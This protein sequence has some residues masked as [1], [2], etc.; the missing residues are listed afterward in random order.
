MTTLRTGRWSTLQKLVPVI[1]GL[2]IL[3]V[4]GLTWWF[5]RTYRR[6]RSSRRAQGLYPGTNHFLGHRRNESG[7]SYS[8]T[9]HLNAMNPSQ[10]SLP[11][12]RI[13]LFFSGMLPVRERRR[14]SDWNIE[15][16]PVLPRRSAVIYDTPSRRESVSFFTPPPS[17]HA[18]ND[19]PPASPITNW[20]PFRTISRWWTSANPSKG[21]DYQAVRLLSARK[22]SKFGTDDDNHPESAFTPPPPQNQASNTRSGH[23]SGEEIPPIPA[24]SN[25]ERGSIS[26]PRTQQPED[27]PPSNKRLPSLRPNRPGHIVATEDPSPSQPL[28]YADVS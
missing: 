22:N 28:P 8:S 2:G 24:N 10:L 23:T 18:Q 14:G 3:I 6:R 16:E 21:R 4:A 15:G 26:R 9:S 1:V 12:R 5:Y 7:G 11:V 13:R 19:T 20:S 27:E 25:G 17:V